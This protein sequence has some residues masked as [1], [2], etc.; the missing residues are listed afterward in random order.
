MVL[1][2]NDFVACGQGPSRRCRREVNG[3]FEMMLLILLNGWW[4]PPRRYQLPLCS[5]TRE[6][7]GTMTS[8]RTPATAQRI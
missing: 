5:G 1:V 4:F 8:N 6:T 7:S 3:P 2:A